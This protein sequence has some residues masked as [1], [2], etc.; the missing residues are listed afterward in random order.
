MFDGEDC[1]NRGEKV[2][3]MDK[4]PD[5]RPGKSVKLWYAQSA[6]EKKDGKGRDKLIIG[7]IG[8]Q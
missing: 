4:F 3:M 2:E 5:F 1:L 7:L 8:T 6:M